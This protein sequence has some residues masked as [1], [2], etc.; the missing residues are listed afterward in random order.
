[1]VQ[2]RPRD[3]SKR[4]GIADIVFCIDAT[5]SMSPFLDTVKERIK[6]FVVK[7]GTSDEHQKIPVDWR[8]KVVGYRDAFEDG[9]DWIVGLDNPF[10]NNPEEV[11]RQLAELMPEGGGDDPE[12]LM[13]ALYSIVSH[14]RN[15]NE[16]REPVHRI[17]IVI[18][19]E[20]SKD[21]MHENTVEPGEPQDGNHL[22]NL[23]VME[24]IKLIYYGPECEVI[25]N[26]ASVPGSQIKSCSTLGDGLR[27]ID[28][29]E[30]LDFLRK[31]I[32]ETSAPTPAPSRS[33]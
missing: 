17:I 6:D 20:R 31:T 10:S 23:L 15:E 13:D 22:L 14:A 18:T 12:T 33:V 29:D 8:I 5:G 4:K 16:W 1:M 25:E 2:Q 32:S 9:T 27:S 3:V 7:L 26:L 24:K 11:Y 19:D 28:W 30:Q 21:K